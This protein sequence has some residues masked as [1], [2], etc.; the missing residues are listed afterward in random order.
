MKIIDEYE[1]INTKIKKIEVSE[2]IIKNH[3]QR[4]LKDMED[5]VSIKF[6]VFDKK[7]NF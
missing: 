7:K 6:N 5:M 2:Q 4:I 1:Q 3:K